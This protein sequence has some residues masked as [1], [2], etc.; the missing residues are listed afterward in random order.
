MI[1]CNCV[2]T[3]RVIK[4][5]NPE[6]S[7][8]EIVS[9]FHGAESGWKAAENFQRVFRNRQA[10][11]EMKE[12]RIK[13]IPGAI[14]ATVPESPNTSK[15][16]TITLPTGF[17]KWSKILAQIE[18]VPSASEAERLIKQGG[19]EINGVQIQDPSCKLNLDLREA[20]QVRLGKKKFLHVVV[21]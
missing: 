9:G 6:V 16:F 18:E 4:V 10:P 13:R 15:Q 1:D 2:I 8:A 12:I 14:F 19:F 7:L 11:Q 17:E 21:E 20:Y 3:R 5:F